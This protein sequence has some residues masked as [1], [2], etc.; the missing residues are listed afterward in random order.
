MPARKFQPGFR[1]SALDVCIL[2]VG[3]VASAYAMTVDPWF[4]I[5]IVFVVLHF[6]LFC[7]VLRMSRPLELTWA[8]IFVGLAV[9]TICWK[10][11]SWPD[12]VC[13]RFGRDVNRRIYRNATSIISRR[14]LAEVERAFAR[15]VGV[16]ESQQWVKPHASWE[17][18]T[19]RTLRVR[20]HTFLE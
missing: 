20:S 1:L 2:I 11:L 5:A 17:H 10:L 14:R 7:N 16:Q 15:V 13:N 8:G 3:G 19:L 9:A 12:D 6:F 18:A 4:G